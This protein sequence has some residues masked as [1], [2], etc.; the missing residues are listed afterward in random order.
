M[1]PLEDAKPS[2]LTAMPV[3]ESNSA[4]NNAINAEIA[5]LVKSSLETLVKTELL[6]LATNSTM[7]QLTVAPTAQPVNCQLLTQSMV[8]LVF[9]ETSN[10]LVTQTVK[11][12]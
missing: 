2:L 3:E 9:A 7:L 1:P 11:F 5:Q 10:K 8:S 12:N 4:N 6:V